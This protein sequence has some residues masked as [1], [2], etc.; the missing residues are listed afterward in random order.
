MGAMAGSE[1]VATGCGG[2]VEARAFTLGDPVAYERA[3]ENGPVEKA[4]GGVVY[5]THKEAQQ[6]IDAFQGHLPPT[7]FEGQLLPGRVYGFE[8]PGPICEMTER[9]RY[10]LGLRVPA[11]ISRC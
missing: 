1:R 7:W 5:R 10:G 4:I 6:T 11:K 8:L 2:S 9:K 3:L